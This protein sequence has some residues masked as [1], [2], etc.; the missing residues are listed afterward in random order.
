MRIL[1][2]RR[3]E[4]VMSA[5]MM[6]AAFASLVDAATVPKITAPKPAI[7]RIAA[8]YS[9]TAACSGFDSS[10][11]PPW[12]MAPVSGTNQANASVLPVSALGR[13]RFTVDKPVASV[14]PLNLP[15]SPGTLTVTGI[16]KDDTGRVVARTATSGVLGPLRLSVKARPTDVTVAIHAITEE[17][18]DVQLIPVGKGE[19]GQTCITA[20]ANGT[21]DSTASGDDTVSGTSITTGPDGI[22]NSTAGGDDVQVI[23]VGKGKP[24]VPCVSKGA[25]G[26]RDSRPLGDDIGVADTADIMTG[27]D[28]ICNTPANATNLVPTNV[29]TAASVQT[30][31][32]QVFGQ[33]ANLFFSVA[34]SDKIVN[35][36]LD[37][38]GGVP[39]P[40]PGALISDEMLAISAAAKSAT[41]L[42]VYF[43]NV[44]DAPNATTIPVRLE[45]WIQDAH[46]AETSENIAAHE[47]AH[48]LGLLDR[49]DA[50]S[51][52]DLMYFQTNSANPNPCNLRQFAWGVVNP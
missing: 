8:S 46:G 49:S 51:I 31:L 26:F 4:A 22:C 39:D 15:T 37:R 50:A 19:A 5:I 27:A 32:N 14:S 35:Y 45:S 44:M 7:G 6:L 3:T 11:T 47:L 25:N 38:N 10:T 24:S 42:N 23:A 9:Q 43:V 13:V 34:R 33:Q 21:R 40:A 41:N 17:N 48:S 2:T 30:Y 36:D 20:G 18:D 12:L 52:S 1:M 29:P 16:T 28:G